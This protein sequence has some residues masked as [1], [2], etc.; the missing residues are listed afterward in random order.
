MNNRA[1][2]SPANNQAE[3]SGEPQ[4]SG[5]VYA[6]YGNVVDVCFTPPLPPRNR[7]LRIETKPP[8]VLEVQAHI[9]TNT[10]RCI[11]LNTARR[12]ARGAKVCDTNT[13]IE[14]PVGRELIGRMIDMFGNPVDGGD[15]IQSKEHWSIHQP[16]LPLPDRATS[17]TIFETGI[18]AIDLLS[19]LERGGKSGL[20]GG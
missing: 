20:F 8:I 12:I 4:R 6:V 11:A 5:K 9:D 14:V 16:R 1:K 15:A 3:S 2:D 13:T 17:N 10:V 19:P 18:K 7:Q